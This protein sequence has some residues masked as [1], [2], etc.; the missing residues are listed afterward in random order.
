MIEVIWHGRGGQGAFTAARLLGVAGSIFANKYALAFPTFG[1]ER[2]GAPVLGFTKL[3]DQKITDRSEVVQADF[4][5]FLDETL[6]DTHVKNE[7]KPDGVL[8]V[9]TK[10]ISRYREFHG[11]V[12]GIDATGYA[13]KILQ[14][15]IV[16]TA[17]L[18]A[19][20]AVFKEIKLD[21]LIGAIR[22]EMKPAVVEKNIELLKVSY[23]SVIRE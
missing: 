20:A 11:R 5:V 1:P 23:E 4:S 7:L 6:L 19:L 12:V 9:N 22:K 10:D 15:P 21:A 13:L 17:L 2:R 3:S 18:G 16:N 8:I 14:R